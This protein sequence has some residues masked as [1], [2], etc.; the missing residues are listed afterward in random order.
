MRFRVPDS[1]ARCGGLADSGQQHC[2]LGGHPREEDLHTVCM[3]S[4]SLPHTP[5]LQ[6]SVTRGQGPQGGIMRTKIQRLAL[7][8]VV[9]G[10]L[11]VMALSA[12]ASAATTQISGVGVTDTEIWVVAALAGAER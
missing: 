5:E 11:L 10:G 1:T 6:C 7:L 2:G 12:P 9:M 8:A 3:R 4:A